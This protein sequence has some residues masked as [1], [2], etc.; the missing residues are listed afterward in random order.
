MRTT[1]LALTASLCLALPTFAQDSAPQTPVPVETVEAPV[2][3][4]LAA[5]LAENADQIAKP[6]RQTIGPV[7]AAIGAAGPGRD[8]I[9]H[10]TGHRTAMAEA[11]PLI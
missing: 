9:R 8:P 5:V 4:G 7:I 1:L 2:L 10:P 11:R 3:T 6:S